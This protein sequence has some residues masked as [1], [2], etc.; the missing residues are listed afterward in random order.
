MWVTARPSTALTVV[1]VVVVAEEEE[2]AVCTPLR[3]V[4][5]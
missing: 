1:V 2:E 5:G 3:W 4:V